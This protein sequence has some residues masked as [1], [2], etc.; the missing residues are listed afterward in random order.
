MPDAEP[1]SERQALYLKRAAEFRELSRTATDPVL[2]NAYSQI[3]ENYAAL[4][5]IVTGEDC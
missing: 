5:K 3:A 1:V 2:T 4:A